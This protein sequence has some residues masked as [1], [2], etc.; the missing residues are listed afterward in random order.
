MAT[1]SDLNELA[2]A[3]HISALGAH[4]IWRLAALQVPSKQYFGVDELEFKG[5]APRSAA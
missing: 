1:M 5:P 4:R 3:I 2:L